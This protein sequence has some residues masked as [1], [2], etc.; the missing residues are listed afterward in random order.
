MKARTRIN[1]KKVL[2]VAIILLLLALAT[3]ILLLTRDKER[4]LAAPEATLTVPEPD[5]RL[6]VSEEFTIPA[7]KTI[8]DL[9]APYGFSPAR[10]IEIR[11]AVRPVYDLAKIPAGQKISLLRRGEDYTAFQLDLDPERYLEVNLEARP[12]SASIKSRPVTRQLVLIEGIIKDSLIA[13]VN[14]AGEQDLLALMM[15]EIFGWVIDFFVDLRQG[16]NFRLLVEK[17]YIDGR[18]GSYGPILA[19]RFVNRGQ[20]FEAYRYEFPDTGKADYF[21]AGGGSLRKEFL[22]SPLRYA[23]ITSRFSSSRLHPIR[24]IYRPHYGIDYAAPVGTPVQATADGVVTFAGWNGAAGR[25]VRIRHRNAY[26]TMYLHLKSLAAGI[27][28]GARVEGGQVIGY[29]GLSG[30][31]T[32][33]HLDYRLLYH[34]KYVNPLSWKFQ[35]AEP[36]PSRYR[37]DFEKKVQGLKMLLLFPLTYL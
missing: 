16:D 29:V 12:P 10:V 36:L 32:G 37:A 8:T 18:F 25:M 14:Q 27:K 3:I 33:P 9:L 13:A 28:T 2:A 15:A 6:P 19:A 35:P 11:E 20:V 21:E 22:K 4:P 31:S 17:K 23:R 26:E 24:K 34:G 7:G 1:R 30:E 5:I